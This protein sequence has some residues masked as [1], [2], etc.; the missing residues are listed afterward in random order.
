MSRT[1]IARTPS[2]STWERKSLADLGL[3][4]GIAFMRRRS[5]ILVLVLSLLAPGCSL[6]RPSSS[7]VPLHLVID[8]GS[9]GTRL[10]LFGIKYLEGQCSAVDLRPPYDRCSQFAETQGL[11][12]MG[13]EKAKQA[14]ESA[15]SQIDGD[16]RNE[17]RAAALLG[18]GGF[19]K[20]PK[21]RR[22]AI[23]D[24]IRAAFD[25]HSLPVR[26]EVITGEQEGTL[27]W[28]TVSQNFSS[29]DHI[30]L[31]T[32][33]ATVQLAYGTVDAIKSASSPVGISEAFIT[34]REE[35]NFSYCYH[36]KT[37]GRRDVDYDNCRRYVR[38]RLFDGSAIQQLARG[39]DP[40]RK[41][42]AI[43]AIG[44]SWRA[45]F[46]VLGSNELSLSDIIEQGRKL[47]KIDPDKLP[48]H[49]IA[50]R[51]APRACFQYAYQAGLLEATGFQKIRNGFESWPKGAAISKEYFPDCE[52]RPGK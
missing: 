31:E 21:E 12:D 22:E 44:G 23:L 48:D 26:L 10:C 5:I 34:L 52:Q 49:G 36:Q 14:V 13:D 19:R 45:T 42:Q 33:G 1:E 27:A 40:E 51:F 3:F 24:R 6:L 4:V 32:G 35:G 47:C 38:A 16:T 50:K 11:A 2:L 18:T 28:K 17:I 25:A 37:A 29:L 30:I 8:A 39:I 9:S 7:D 46:S 15:L 43:Y 41:Q 20:L